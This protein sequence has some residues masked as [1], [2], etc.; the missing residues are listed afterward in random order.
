MFKAKRSIKLEIDD[1]NL[2]TL[3][4]HGNLKPGEI[5][6]ALLSS[7]FRVLKYLVENENIPTEII[8]QLVI[9]QLDAEI[10]QKK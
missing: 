3:K 5:A 6:D 7:L 1:N 8:R 4:F 10:P 9:D 2:C